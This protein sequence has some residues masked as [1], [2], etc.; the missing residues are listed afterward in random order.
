MQ[1]RQAV[2]LGQKRLLLLI[3]PSPA[4]VAHPGVDQDNQGEQEHADGDHRRKHTVGILLPGHPLEQNH[5]AKD[6]QNRQHQISQHVV[7]AAQLQSDGHHQQQEQPDPVDQ[8]PLA[9][10]GRPPGGGR[11]RQQH[12]VD[13]VVHQQKCHGRC[14]HQIEI[15]ENQGI[16]HRRG[17]R[18][19]PG[20]Q[21]Q[22][23]NPDQGAQTAGPSDQRPQVLL[24]HRTGGIRL[25]SA[26]D[27][28][29][30][31]AAHA[32]PP[33]LHALPKPPLRIPPEI[34]H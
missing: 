17:G 27:L 32:V 9:D 20:R 14:R 22:Q 3:A 11:K 4:G 25:G 21:G 26:E 5:G 1:H 30:L 2:R 29:A 34:G 18:N 28:T 33:L 10:A 24:R 15:G 12:R 19:S 23:Q 31:A 16:H 7:S 8:I 6:H 13:R